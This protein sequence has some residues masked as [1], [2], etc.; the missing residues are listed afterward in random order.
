MFV[1]LK[2]RYN[3]S[4]KFVNRQQGVIELDPYSVQPL[5]T[6]VVVERTEEMFHALFQLFTLTILRSLSSLTSPRTAPFQSIHWVGFRLAKIDP[7]HT[8]QEEG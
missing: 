3:M 7:C 5:W 2:V 1:E 6:I 8:L 4:S